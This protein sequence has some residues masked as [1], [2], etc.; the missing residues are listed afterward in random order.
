MEAVQQLHAPVSAS[1]R[2]TTNTDS[3]ERVIASAECR[4]STCDIS[5]AMMPASSS[6][7]R[8]KLINP[9]QHNSTCNKCQV[10]SAIRRG[11]SFELTS[12]C[13]RSDLCTGTNTSARV[14]QDR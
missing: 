9:A 6:S 11:E 5:C 13:T 1:I 3:I 12:M 8:I 2:A 14:L 10:H 7:V 4:A